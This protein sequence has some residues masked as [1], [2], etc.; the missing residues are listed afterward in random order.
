MVDLG[1]WRKAQRYE[2]SYWQNKAD[3]IASG[4]IEQL[5]WYEWKANEME[6]NIEEVGKIDTKQFNKVL[7][8]GSG[9]IGIVSY[10]KW[11]ERYTLDPL[12]DFYR[13][14]HE[15]SRLRDGSVHY[16]K[17]V[18]E[19]LPFQNS[20]FS[21]V[22]LDNVIDHVRN[23]E[24]VLEEAHRVLAPNGV[25]YLAVNIHTTWGYYLHRLLSKLN[26]DRGHP[27]SFNERII[28]CFIRKLHFD[29]LYEKHDNYYSNREK[30]RKSD[31]L[32]ERIK[33]YTGLSEFI[34]YAVCKKIVE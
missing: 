22:I 24:G 9:P 32:K 21:L 6:R 31:L 15:L 16:C 33:G 25:L 27:Y 26:I 1:R 7:E 18:G 30:D 20:W 34:Y 17:G 3:K 29:I 4:S 19:E 13:S 23:A 14:N 2:Q 11:G 5:H 28:N 10:C 8:I 12:E